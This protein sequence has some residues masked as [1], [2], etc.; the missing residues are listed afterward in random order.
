MHGDH[1][2]TRG[3]GDLVRRIAHAER[4]EDARAQECV[5]RLTRYLL[6][7]RAELTGAGAVAPLLAGIVDEWE[8]GFRLAGGLELE[9]QRIGEAVADAGGM[10]QQI[11]DRD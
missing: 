4:L 2:L 5:E 11:A 8:V 3:R 10:R 9:E 7:D 6:D 1:A